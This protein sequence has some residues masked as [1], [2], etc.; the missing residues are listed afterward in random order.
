MTP[1]TTD[2]AEDTA[3]L[4]RQLMRDEGLRRYP[5][6]DTTGHLTIGIGHNLDVKGLS[7]AAIDL[8]FWEDVADVT[9]DLDRRLPWWR[10][11]NRA[12]QRVL[13][14]M[15]FNLGVSGLLTFRHTLAHIQAQR[16]DEA[17]VEMLN[18]RWAGQVGQRAVRL[19]H[20][21]R[22]GEDS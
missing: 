20:I 12:R 18:S 5:Y 14:N 17:A 19:S 11:L 1:P 13:I 21:M 8:I 10:T 7:A 3:R 16:F 15:A 2:D 4:K 9:T 22:S 6:S